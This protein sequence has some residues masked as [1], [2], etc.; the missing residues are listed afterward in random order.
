[1]VHALTLTIVHFVL[2]SVMFCL[3][4]LDGVIWIIIPLFFV[5]VMTCDLVINLRNLIGDDTETVHLVSYSTFVSQLY[6]IPTMCLVAR[7]NISRYRVLKKTGNP[8][9][10]P[11]YIAETL[12]YIRYS[13]LIS[14][15]YITFGLLAVWPIINSVLVIYTLVKTDVIHCYLHVYI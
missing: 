7:L 4:T 3:H 5:T 13:R 1:M 12:K 8:I 14:G 6:A 10:G 9:L 2:V 15:Q 11:G